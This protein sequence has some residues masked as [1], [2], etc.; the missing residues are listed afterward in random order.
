MPI[1]G[2]LHQDDGW[3]VRKDT[4]A[5]VRDAQV[6]HID[7]EVISR[8]V[9]LPIAVDRNG[10]NMVGMSVGENSS[11]ANLY[12]Q[13]CRLEYWHLQRWEGR[14]NKATLRLRNE[15]SKEESGVIRDGIVWEQRIGLPNAQTLYT[16]MTCVTNLKLCLCRLASVNTP[17]ERWW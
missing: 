8:Q 17:A 10:V 3:A 16:Y 12:H 7:A 4:E 13:I 5:P 15:K 6:P 2:E 14:K 11:G 9:G 1:R